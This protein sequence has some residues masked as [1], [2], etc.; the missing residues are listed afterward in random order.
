MVARWDPVHGSK[1]DVDIPPNF[2]PGIVPVLHDILQR[3]STK[4]QTRQ[5]VLSRDV[6]HIR[7]ALTFDV[8]KSASYTNDCAPSDT[9]AGWGCG[10]RN[11]LMALTSLL[12]A[13]PA[14][15]KPFSE[16]DNG[17]SPGVRRIQGWIE[18]AWGMGYDPEGK[19]HFKGKLLGSKKWIGTSDLYAMFVYKG[20][21]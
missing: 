9:L 18:E 11:A 4:G 20:V 3:S 12:Q 19:K 2:S 13:K 16:V 7:Y 10:Y 8:G 6:V 14:Y 21:P 5:A 17:A 1:T 15:R